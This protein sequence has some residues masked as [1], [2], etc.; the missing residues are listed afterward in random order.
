MFVFA[1]AHWMND[2]NKDSGAYLHG[3]ARALDLKRQDHRVCERVE[4]IHP[5]TFETL[6]FISLTQ[7]VFLLA[8][9]YYFYSSLSS[10]FSC[11][12]LRNGEGFS[13]E[14]EK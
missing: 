3:N 14:L 4:H 6:N 13:N 11:S 2:A 9:S 7:N 5:R 8:W 12:S 10:Y 1:F